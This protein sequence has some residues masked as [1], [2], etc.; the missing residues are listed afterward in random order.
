MTTEDEDADMITVDEWLKFCMEHIIAKAATHAT[1]L[2]STTELWRNLKH[3]LMQTKI[4]RDFSHNL[5][6]TRY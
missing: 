5:E 6:I 3:L 4:A 2:F 1:L